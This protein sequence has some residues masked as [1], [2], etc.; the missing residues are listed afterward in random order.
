[1]LRKVIAWPFSPQNVQWCLA[2]HQ[3]PREVSSSRRGAD[4]GALGAVAEGVEVGVEAGDWQGV[5]V[6]DRRGGRG[7]DARAVPAH[8]QARH[9]VHRRAGAHPLDEGGERHV[10]LAAADDVHEREARVQL[11]AHV[12][13][14]VGAAEDG[15][16]AGMAF[17]DPPGE[18][19][20]GEV[21]LEG[22]GEPD[23]VV[24]RPGDRGQAA[25]EEA[26]AGAAQPPQPGDRLL[27]LPVDAA[28]DGLVVRGV[29]RRS[30]A[31]ERGGE[32]PL[33]GEGGVRQP[34]LHPL[35]VRQADEIGEVE[36][37]IADVAGHAVAPERGLEQA[38]PE[39]GAVE[40]V[41][42]HADQQDAVGG[43]GRA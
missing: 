14:P 34:A 37:E 16:D 6:G 19:E 27:G 31:V 15:D 43:H 9:L 4:G 2:P 33:A 21:L 41:P 11:V 35:V 10:G 36:A 30:F 40:P 5:E 22:G 25:V 18:R 23:E 42:G 8:D 17:L 1:M 20:R 26:G 13:F 7:A 38:Q 39:R 3:Q 12:A 29:G 24:V 32:Q 28:Q